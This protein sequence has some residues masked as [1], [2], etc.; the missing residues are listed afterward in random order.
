MKPSFYESIVSPHVEQ[1]NKKPRKT[2]PSKVLSM[3]TVQRRPLANGDTLWRD[4][5][6]HVT[7]QVNMQ[8]PVGK[9]R[10]GDFHMICQGKAQAKRLSHQ[11]LMQPFGL[12][13]LF[14]RRPFH[15]QTR[16]FE[17]DIQIVLAEPGQRQRDAIVVIVAFSMLYGGNVWCSVVLC[18]ALASLSKP[19][20]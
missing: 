19:I 2:G 7:D 12:G 8:Q 4:G 13:F 6:R 3:L 15:G 10:A 11:P 9:G 5:F 1:K 14:F 18:R 20:H 17:L 16:A